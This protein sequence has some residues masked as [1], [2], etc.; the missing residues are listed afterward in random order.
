[1]PDTKL[2]FPPKSKEE[3]AFDLARQIV[4]TGNV[5]DE[6]FHKRYLDLYTK[7]LKAVQGEDPAS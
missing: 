5:I 7:C 4:E 1:M 6:T 3:V 2:E